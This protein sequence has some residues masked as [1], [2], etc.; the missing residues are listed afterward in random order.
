MPRR[1]G[2]PAAPT[3]F[4]ERLEENPLLGRVAEAFDAP[5]GALL[6]SGPLS[7]AL[8]G[9]A[10]G[11]AVHPLLIQ[12][13]LGAMLSAGV[14]DLT[15]GARAGSQSRLLMG[16]TCLAVVP[17]ALSGWAEWANADDRTKRVGIAHAALNITGA[18]A[19]VA[20]YLVRRRRWSPTAAV[21]TGL[22]GVA[23]SGGG[24]LGGHLSLVRKYASHDRPSDLEGTLRGRFAG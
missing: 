23:F 14:L 2:K 16:V 21:L 24:M 6:G 3:V 5:V 8:R 19:S 22:A 9:R 20:S 17:A 10:V 12:V 13:P 11:H 7:D 4:L 18:L 1:N 15:Q